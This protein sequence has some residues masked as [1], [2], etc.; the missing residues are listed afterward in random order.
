MKERQADDAAAHAAARS[1]LVDP[2]LPETLVALYHDP[3][4]DD[5]R[6]ASAIADASARAE[7]DL[8]S[9]PLNGGLGFCRVFWLRKKQI[10]WED[11]GIEWRSPADR[12]PCV[13]FEEREPT[14]SDEPPSTRG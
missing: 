13:L 4:A 3:M 10:L 8:E 5:P 2:G 12:H 14:A 9:H 1:R 6:Y 7:R 11:H